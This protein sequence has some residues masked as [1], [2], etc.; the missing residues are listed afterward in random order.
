MEVSR[1][2]LWQGFSFRQVCPNCHVP[3]T[4]YGGNESFASAMTSTTRTV[5][6]LEGR[7]DREVNDNFEPPNFNPPNI[8]MA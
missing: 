8:N 3:N 4:F 5:Y 1:Y 6:N 7:V 2:E